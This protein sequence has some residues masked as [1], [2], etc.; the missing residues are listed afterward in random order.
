MKGDAVMFNWKVRFKNRHWVMAFVSQILIIAEVI[1]S[2]LHSMGLIHF[3]L[4]DAVQNSILTVINAVFII[5]SMLG[6]V[7]DPTT[8]G[9]KD[10]ERALKYDKPN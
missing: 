10:S 8:K 3:Q 1:L 5:L 6:I 2:G 4:T 7:Q 9:Y